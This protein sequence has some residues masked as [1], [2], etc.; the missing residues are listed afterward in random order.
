MRAKSPLSLSLLLLLPKNG[1]KPCGVRA[2]SN[3]LGKA[4]DA[5]WSFFHQ[6]YPNLA[7]GRSVA[8]QISDYL[9]RYDPGGALL[10]MACKAGVP[11]QY[12]EPGELRDVDTLKDLY[13]FNCRV[14]AQIGL[15]QIKGD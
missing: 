15:H 6:K 2:G 5:L 14:L 8:G 9:P 3:W 4:L 11:K 10:L 7:V 1:Q 12:G 13:E